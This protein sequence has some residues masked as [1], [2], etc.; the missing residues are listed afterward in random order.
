MNKY[1]GFFSIDIYNLGGIGE[2]R[3]SEE[4]KWI[5]QEYAQDIKQVADVDR[6][7]IELQISDEFIDEELDRYRTL[8]FSFVMSSEKE[9]GQLHQELFRRL[10]DI[11]TVFGADVEL[12]SYFA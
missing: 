4:A 9:K 10:R 1:L 8:K 11:D 12:E 5:V 6:M 3:V 2:T 7:S